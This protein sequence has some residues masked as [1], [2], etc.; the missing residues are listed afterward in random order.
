MKTPN[1]RLRRIGNH[2]KQ[3][4]KISA[5]VAPGDVLEVSEDLAA[6]LHAANPALRDGE[7]AVA[8]PAAE[9]SESTTEE[10]PKPKRGRVRKAAS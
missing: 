3:P 1:P 8:P 5:I 7:P 4:A 2:S 9:V 6:Q 10:A